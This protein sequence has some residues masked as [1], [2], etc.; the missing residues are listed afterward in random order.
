MW[1]VIQAIDKDGGGNLNRQELKFA[2]VDKLKIMTDKEAEALI[3]A[4]DRN[5]DGIVSW[6]EFRRAFHL[7]QVSSLKGHSI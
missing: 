6:D 1:H 2:F 4:L 5:K 3:S 7:I